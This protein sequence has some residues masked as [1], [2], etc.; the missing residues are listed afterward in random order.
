MALFSYCYVFC[1][2][3]QCVWPLVLMDSS[4][5]LI[6]KNV[7]WWN[8]RVTSSLI[9]KM[10]QMKS[11]VVSELSLLFFVHVVVCVL[12]F[13]WWNCAK[14]SVDETSINGYILLYFLG[15]A[16]VT[17]RNIHVDG[18]KAVVM[19]FNGDLRWQTSVLS[20]VWITLQDHLGVGIHSQLWHLLSFMCKF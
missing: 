20:P 10:D 13:V 18:L 15:Q 17:L 8:K 19:R 2:Q 14:C 4:C 9:V 5:V 6:H 12:W 16:L 7:F 1:V 3:F 11:F